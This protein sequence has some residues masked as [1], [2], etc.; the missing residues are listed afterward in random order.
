MNMRILVSICTLDRDEGL[1]KCLE[2]ITRQILPSNVSV[3]VCVTVN[4]DSISDST[5]EIVHSF[6]WPSETPV[7]LAESRPGIPHA[8]NRGLQHALDNNY[9][10]IAFIDDDAFAAP[11]WLGR[12]VD[13]F[14]D[15]WCAVGGPQKSIVPSLG[16]PSLEASKIYAGRKL[17][18]G[19]ET[20]WTATNNALADLSEI[21]K[22]GIRFD[23]DFAECGGSDTLFFWQ[24]TRASG[25]SIRWNAE[26]IVTEPVPLSRM[27][28]LWL[29]R[30]AYRYGASGALIHRKVLGRWQGFKACAINAARLILKS[31]SAF[32]AAARGRRS[33][34]DGA[35]DIVLGIGYLLGQFRAARPR[36]YV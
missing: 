22:H 26:A 11:D 2:S 25:K 31:P 32:V 19:A 7:L 15:R 5:R 30:R 16:R 28:A 13:S 20:W 18:S 33:M 27:S 36:R 9:T 34:F 1:R 4:K 35:T 21:R 23:S 6:D 14:G 17:A 29:F 24:L 3:S 12:L 8:R 10:H